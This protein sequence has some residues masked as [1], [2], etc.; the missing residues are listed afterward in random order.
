MLVTLRVKFNNILLYSQ[1]LNYLVFVQT[2]GHLQLSLIQI[3]KVHCVTGSKYKFA[4]IV[5]EIAANDHRF[6]QL[7]NMI[8]T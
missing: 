1:L 3:T 6:G 7:L 4:L 8:L 5:Q 2:L